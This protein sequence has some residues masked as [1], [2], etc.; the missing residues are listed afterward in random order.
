MPA[1]PT[2][3]IYSEYSTKKTLNTWLWAAH[4]VIFYAEPRYTKDLDIWIN[5]TVLNAARVYRALGRFGA[6]LRD[7]QAAISPSRILSIR[8]ALLLTGLI[9]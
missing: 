6:P 1:N 8:L 3:K 7:I 5:S 9:F 4:A 2:S